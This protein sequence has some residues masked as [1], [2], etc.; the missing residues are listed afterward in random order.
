LCIEKKN[1]KNNY[2]LPH[3]DNLLYQF[4]GAKYFISIYFKSR[5][6]Q[7]HIANMDIE[8]MVRRTNYGSYEFLMMP[9][10]LCDALFTFTTL[11]NSIP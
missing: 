8:K 10:E 2:S 6:Y 4:N 7:I 5:Y 9:F 11:M 3:I 1:I